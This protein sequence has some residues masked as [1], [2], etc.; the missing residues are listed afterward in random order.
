M[1]HRV[2][3]LFVSCLLYVTANCFGQPN[4]QPPPFPSQSSPVDVFRMLMTTNAA[5]REQFLASKSPEARRVIETKL[6]EYSIM[7]ADQREARLR[8]LQIR[9]YT[10][11]LMRLDSAE[12]AK[13]LAGL[14]EA[15][16]AAVQARLGTF[17]ILP[18]P[19]QREVVSNAAVMRI[20]AGG[21]WIPDGGPVRPDLSEEERQA[22]LRKQQLL[23]HFKDFFELPRTQQSKALARL[24][25]QDREQMEK[26][27]S[28][29]SSL[30]GQER[31]DAIEGFKKFAD[32]SPSE[33]IAFLNTAARWRTMSES[34]RA[35]WRKIV[36]RLQ[37]A[38]PKLPMPSAEAAKPQPSP[39]SLLGK[40][41]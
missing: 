9:W 30:P 27:L 11:Q 36:G 33:R 6:R 25:Q 38:P 14:S 1:T 35:L 15:D 17:E 40:T 3:V 24:S 32:L 23:D 5:G 18:P 12:R 13:R 10:L 20:L 2:P 39:A 37:A 4:I 22:E 41:N 21:V 34:D 8:A 16:R 31:E 19:I 29:F 28:M 7:V 26:T